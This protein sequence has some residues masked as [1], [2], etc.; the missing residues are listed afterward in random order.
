[1]SSISIKGGNPLCG[2]VFVHGSKNAVLPILAASLLVTDGRTKLTCCP[3]ISDIACLNTLLEELGCTVSFRDGIITIDAVNAYYADLKKEIVNKTRGSFLMLGALIGRFHKAVIANPGGCT[4]G[5]RPVDIHVEALKQM[6]VSS[7]GTKDKWNCSAEHL[8]GATITLPSPSVGA[9]ENV[10]LTAVLAKGTTMLYN[11]AKEPEIT[12]LINFLNGAGASISETGSGAYEIKGVE[13]L[14]G[15]EFVVPPDRIV[16]GTYLIAV[17]A[18][19]GHAVIHNV[20]EEEQRNLIDILKISGCEIIVGDNTCE[21]ISKERLKAI[22]LTTEP[23]PGFPTDLQPQIL[24]ALT[25]AEGVSKITDTIFPSRFHICSELKKM[26]TDIEC[27]APMVAVIGVDKLK[28]TDITAQDLRGGAAL[29]I[30]GL[31]AEGVTNV[32]GVDY[33]LR[34]YEDICR[35]L[36]RLGADI[37]IIEE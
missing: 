32:F 9:T 34:G 17:A 21:I 35:D 11:A 33:I 23:Y 6:G 12:A 18:T 8:C 16:A 31:M 1:M 30:A 37:Q 10:I 24:T 15:S 22:D 27:N 4:I 19:R 2:K 28:G 26:G 3:D 14:H 29:C 13:S 20:K 36:G 5:E 25:M 7:Y